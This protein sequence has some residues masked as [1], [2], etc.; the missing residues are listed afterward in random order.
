MSI[1]S[2]L[3]PSRH[4]K[5][6]ECSLSTGRIRPPPRSC[7]A[8]ASAAGG[9]EALLVREREVDAALERPERRVDP[10]EA[11]DGVED[12][13]GLGAVEE[14]GEIAADLLQRRVDVVERRRAGRSRAQL[15]LGMRLDDLDRL[16]AD[17]A[18]RAE[19]SDALH[20]REV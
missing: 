1:C 12:D 2:P 13:V 4:W 11:D 15:E 9:D 7:A 3:R 16:A 20:A 19:E 14:L 17:R 6:A 10:R 5:S 8:S 18:G